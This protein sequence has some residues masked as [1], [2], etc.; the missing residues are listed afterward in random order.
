ML[1]KQN[2]ENYVLIIYLSQICNIVHTMPAAGY[3]ITHI[4]NPMQKEVLVV[5]AMYPRNTLVS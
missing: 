4:I 1:P 5:L 3:Q 2:Y